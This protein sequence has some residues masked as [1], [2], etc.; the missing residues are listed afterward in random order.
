MCAGGACTLGSVSGG[1]VGHDDRGSEIE[2]GR[3]RVNDGGRMS[4]RGDR[5]SEGG[6]GRVIRSGGAC[7]LA[8]RSG[9]GGGRDRVSD[10]G[11]GA[12]RGRDCDPVVC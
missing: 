8:S 5:V 2:N 11:I 4:G 3:G 12:G 6:G 9:S 7:D 10:G 1:D